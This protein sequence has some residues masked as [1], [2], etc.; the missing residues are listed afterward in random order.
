MG[1]WVLMATVEQ[2]QPLWI[3]VRQKIVLEC[4]K[5]V[6]PNQSM[7]KMATLYSKCIVHEVQIQN[8][9]DKFSQIHTLIVVD[10]TSSLMARMI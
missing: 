9:Y 3:S 6:M 8:S 10:T 1:I 4:L 5:P 2:N 7:Y